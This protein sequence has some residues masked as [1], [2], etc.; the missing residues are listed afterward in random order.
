MVQ[1]VNDARNS[2][3]CLHFVR[4]RVTRTLTSPPRAAA[5][6]ASSGS[7]SLAVGLFTFTSENL[8]TKADNSFW[9]GPISYK[10]YYDNMLQSV[11]AGTTVVV[12]AGT[13]SAF[14]SALTTITS[15]AAASGALFIIG[16]FLSGLALCFTGL[17]AYNK[18][19]RIDPAVG[20]CGHRSSNCAASVVPAVFAFIVRLRRR[21][22]STPASWFLTGGLPSFPTR[23]TLL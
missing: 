9:S 20:S 19:K 17:A 5:Y 16:I 4:G 14:K 3:L 1:C 23:T 7:G 21:T 2:R 6:K 8:V 12:R 13:C 15:L 18:S 22:H 10:E 11:C